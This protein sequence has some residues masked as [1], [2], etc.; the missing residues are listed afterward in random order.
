MLFIIAYSKL[1]SSRVSFP[2][3]LLASGMSLSPKNVMSEG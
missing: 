2:S 3:H 1:A